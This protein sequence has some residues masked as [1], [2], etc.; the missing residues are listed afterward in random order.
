M[1]RKDS[2][3]SAARL[4]QQVEDFVWKQ[5]NNTFNYKQVSAA[6]GAKTPVNQRAVALALAEMAFDGEVIEVEPGKYKAPER[7]NVATGVFVRR[8]NRRGFGSYFR[9][10][11]QFAPCPQRR[12]R[13]HPC[14][15]PPPRSGA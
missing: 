2:K 13:P 1:P 3:A 6:I 12:S 7:T 11:A 9:G 4:R 15:R 14:R 5:Q 8:S 10:R